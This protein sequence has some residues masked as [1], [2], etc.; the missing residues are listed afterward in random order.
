MTILPLR[1]LFIERQI[2]PEMLSFVSTEEVVELFNMYVTATP[3]ASAIVVAD[4]LFCVFSPTSYF[5]HIHVSQLSPC[6]TILV[7]A[8]ACLCLRVGF[9]L[10]WLSFGLGHVSLILCEGVLVLMLTM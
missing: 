5:D 1:R 9:I 2:Q 7:L 10:L 6:M 3:L 8:C 4:S